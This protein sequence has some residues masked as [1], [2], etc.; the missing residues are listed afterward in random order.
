[1]ASLLRDSTAM[2]VKVDRWCRSS[3]HFGFSRIVV[4]VMVFVHL[5]DAK[6]FSFHS[7]YRFSHSRFEVREVPCSDT[8]GKLV[9]FQQKAQYRVPRVSPSAGC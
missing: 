2:R 6:E 5:P 8:L 1:M 9:S 4:K 3:G 7:L